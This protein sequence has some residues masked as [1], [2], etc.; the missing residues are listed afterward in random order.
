MYAH[1]A[2][3]HVPNGH[4]GL[5]GNRVQPRVALGNNNGLGTLCSTSSSTLHLC[6]NVTF[7]VKFLIYSIALLAYNVPYNDHFLMNS[8]ES[9][10]AKRK[11]RLRMK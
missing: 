5:V 9:S 7:F 11:I 1:A 3:S 2:K 8:V 10:H 6:H 4:I